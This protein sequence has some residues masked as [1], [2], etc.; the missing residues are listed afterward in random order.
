M[1]ETTDNEIYLTNECDHM[2]CDPP[3]CEPSTSVGKQVPP[4]TLEYFVLD[5]RGQ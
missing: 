5:V 2:T 1:E 4:F 3:F